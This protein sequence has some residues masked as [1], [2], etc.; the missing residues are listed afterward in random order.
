M[1]WQRI[2][3]QLVDAP[4]WLSERSQQYSERGVW[5]NGEFVLCW[6]HHAMRAEDNPVL[7]LAALLAKQHDK[8]LLVYFG[9][10]GQHDFNNDRQWM[11]ILEGA[12]ELA[13]GLKDKGLSLRC[14]LPQQKDSR[15]PLRALAARACA[16]VSE[17][18]PLPPTRHW[19]QQLADNSRAPVCRVDGA[20]LVPL[21]HFKQPHGR[22]FAFRKDAQ[23]LIEKALQQQPQPAL[24]R[25]AD[26]QG[27][28]GFTPAD[29]EVSLAGHIAQCPIDHSVAPVPGQ[30]GGSRCGYQRWNGFKQHGLADYHKRRNDAAQNWGYGVSRLSPYLHHGHVSA[31]RIAREAHQQGGPGAEKF[32]DELLIWRE[33]AWHF[34]FHCPDPNCFEQA[35]PKWAQKTLLEHASDER[36]CVDHERLD[37]GQS[38]DALWDLAQRSLRRHGELHNNL[39]MTWAK[40]LIAWR[41]TPHQALESLLTLNHRYALDGND[42]NSYGG[43]LW[44]LGQ[45]DRPFKPAKPIYGTVRARSTKTHAKRLDT[46]AFAEKVNRSPYSMRDPIAIVGAGLAGCMAARTLA[47]HGLPVT[48]LE[49]SRG[50]GGRSATRRERDG[51]SQWDHGAQYF[52]VRDP[53]LARWRDAW[54]EQGLLAR[55]EGEF[56]E[57][58]QAGIIS[59]KGEQPERWVAIPGMSSLCQ[60]LLGNLRMKRRCRVV[61]VVRRGVA[62]WLVDEDGREHGPFGS[63]IITAPPAQAADLLPSDTLREAC[64]AQQLE[65]CWA[66]MARFDVALPVK[67]TGLFINQGPLNWAM[68]DSAKPGRPA[69]HNWLLH[70]SPEWSREHLEKHPAEVCQTLLNAFEAAIG[71]ALPPSSYT[72]A[73]RWRF[74]RGGS[75]HAGGCLWQGEDMLGVAGDW[76][77]GER[78]EGALLSGMAVAGR[79][80]NTLHERRRG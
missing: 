25:V 79:L 21:M 29:L 75:M 63:V 57:I 74:A 66:V 73:H 26:F 53:R 59:P 10:G 40:A 56:G 16:V 22:A 49:K 28:L 19:L 20:C 78:V 13:R 51:N 1:S 62:W 68:H 70:A 8:P 11:F 41:P 64:S 34:C 18:Y 67:Q 47:D 2:D 14:F 35:L 37:A 44:A 39:R 27:E 5:Q 30:V 61:D 71:Q 33:L 55:L 80:M 42:P 54:H 31:M 50:A 77:H 6:L 7:H 45:F 60:H 72:R 38:G 15:S 58:N 24:P 76:L 12:R 3:P 4:D 52:T 65:P 69:G 48:V 43:L 46:Q 17:C 9:L 36:E 23:A 32:L